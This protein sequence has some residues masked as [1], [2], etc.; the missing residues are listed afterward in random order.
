MRRLIVLLCLL[1]G[2]S[3]FA[4][5]MFSYGF[6]L[7]LRQ[8]YFDNAFDF[9]DDSTIFNDDNYFRIK[10]SVWGKWN[11]TDNISL[12]TK[13]TSEPKIAIE[14]DGKLANNRDT[15]DE[16]IFF[17]NLYLDMNFGVVNFRLGRQ[18]F[19][20][21]HGEGFVIMDGT[22]YDGSRSYYFNAVKTTFKIGENNSVDFIYVDDPAKDEYLPVI[23]WQ[24]R[25]V[26]KTDEDGI[27]VYGKFK[28][29][30]NLSLEPY[31][32]Y[33]F[34]DSTPNLTLNTIGNRIVLNL[35]PW[36]IR[37][38]LAY[39]YGEY[40]GGNNREAWGGQAYI[41][42][43]FKEAKLSPS[44]ELGYAIERG[45][46]AYWTNLHLY[47]AKLDMNLTQKTGLSLAYNY[48]MADE[49]REGVAPFFGDGNERGHLGHI[50]LTHKFNQNIDGHLHFEY[51]KP[52]DFYAEANRDDAIFLRWQLQMKF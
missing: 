3:S 38:E 44:F 36:Q 14:S 42:R 34:E 26:V 2:V 48:L 50:I 4:G 23:D 11:F 21:T 25:N 41:K 32:I 29:P 37:G 27:I 1:V 20:M 13:L 19:L 49:S 35:S 43:T 31:Y 9:N 22:P 7:R 18:D 40:K 16:E 33:K 10:A 28:I 6:Y 5:D 51:F 30:E 15:W 12:F 46:P 45:E 24:D 17:D 47:R 39:Q 52:G 8:E